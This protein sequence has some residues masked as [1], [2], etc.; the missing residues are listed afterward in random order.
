VLALFHSAWW[1]RDRSRA[2][3]AVLIGVQPSSGFFI[4]MSEEPHQVLAFNDLMDKTVL[5]YSDVVR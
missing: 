2:D 4:V 5:R 1:A 3:V